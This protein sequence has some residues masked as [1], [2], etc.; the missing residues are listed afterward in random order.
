MSMHINGRDIPWVTLGDLLRDKEAKHG[1]REFAEIAGTKLTYGELAAKSRAVAA[2]LLGY[3]YSAGD[4]IASLTLNSTELL[5]LWFG[6]CQANMIW[7]PINSGLVGDDLIYILRNSGARA[8][9]FDEEATSKVDRV[10][11]EL[12]DLDCFA[13]FDHPTTRPFATLL[14]PASQAMLPQTAPSD[15]GAI[16]YTGGTTGLPKGVVLPQ[17]SFIL[18]GIRYGETFAIRPGERHFSTMPL[19]HAGGLQWAIMG[20]LVNDMTT[21]VDKRFSATRYFDR[22]CETKANIIDPFGPVV[23]MLCNQPEASADKSHSVRIAVGA[24]QGL[25]LHVPQTFVRRF[26]IPLV[27]LYGLTEGGGAM[28]TSDRECSLASNGKPHGWVDI[29]IVGEDDLPLPAGESGE[30]LLRPRFPNMFMKGYFD[31]PQS[32]LRSLRDCWLHTGDLGRIDEK[33]NLNF[34]GRRAHWI[35]RRGESISAIEI[36]TIL[37]KH[38]AVKEIVVVGVPSDL[39]EED[40]KAFVI[41]RPKA[42]LSGDALCDWARDRLAAFKIPRYVE[43]VDDFPRSAAKQEIQR[44]ILKQRSH[45]TAYD[46]ERNRLLSDRASPEAKAS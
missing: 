40:I 23:T 31:D 25:P 9:I 45:A 15:V 13:T 4:R 18:A 12:V 24:V 3:G 11:Q 46:R 41:Q 38:P 8:L 21:V 16:L 1:E 19:Y 39:G 34:L 6:C 22:V 44:N 29:Q 27:S 7:V 14:A 33:G 28:L 32:S 30:I 42:E 17:F 35:R 20:P 37:G 43:L 36:E 5:L 10:R 26:N 2:N